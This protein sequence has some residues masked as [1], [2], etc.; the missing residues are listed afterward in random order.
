MKR[1]ARALRATVFELDR[2]A[3]L[4]G[5]APAPPVPS[6]PTVDLVSFGDG[7]AGDGSSVMTQ[8]VGQQNGSA[9]VNVARGNSYGE[10]NHVTQV[11]VTTDP[12]SPYVGVNVGA[13]DQVV[14]FLPGQNF[15]VLTVPIIAGAANPGEVDVDLRLTPFDPSAPYG[16]TLTT[17]VD[18]LRVMATDPATAPRIV[19]TEGTPQGIQLLFNKPMDPAQASNANNYALFRTSNTTHGSST[20]F[21]F[22]ASLSIST[23]STPVPLKSAEYDAATNTVTLI[24]KRPIASYGPSFFSGFTV[25]Q[26][27]PPRGAARA[28]PNAAHGLVD[29]EGHPIQQAR[30][31]GRFSV[32]V[33]NGPTLFS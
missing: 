25:T 10:V 5:L 11:R 4:A 28:K 13:V 31:P 21:G 33:A 32:G 7:G 2:R 19:A 18:E 26:G 23:K 9:V 3:L 16:L 1:P 24:P 17:S 22:S 8:V 12:S 27:A 29:L 20:F 14:T 30:I 6:M 15:A